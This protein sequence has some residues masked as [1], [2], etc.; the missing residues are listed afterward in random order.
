MRLFCQK[1]SKKYH[2]SIFALIHRVEFG[3]KACGFSPLRGGKVRFPPL[4]LPFRERKIPF[5]S[6]KIPIFD[7]FSSDN[8]ADL[9]KINDLYCLCK[10]NVFS[11][12]FRSP[13]RLLLDMQSQLLEKVIYEWGPRVSASD[14]YKKRAATAVLFTTCEYPVILPIYRRANHWEVLLRCLA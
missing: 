4:F 11:M 13:P 3:A 1:F 6:E 14:K 2:F 8:F 12:C 7:D 10:K 9:L 5:S